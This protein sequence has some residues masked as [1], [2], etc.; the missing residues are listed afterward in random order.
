VIKLRGI[1]DRPEKPR[2][3]VEEGVVPSADIGFYRVPAGRLQGCGLVGFDD[4]RKT[5]TREI[6]EAETGSVILID[7]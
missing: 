7:G 4:R 1:V 5:P 3:I 2:Q 6:E